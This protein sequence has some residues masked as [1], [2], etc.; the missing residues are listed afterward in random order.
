MGLRNRLVG[1]IEVSG[2]P[3]PV[4]AA[5]LYWATITNGAPPLGGG[6]SQDPAPLPA[7][8]SAIAPLRGVVVGTGPQLCWAANRITVYRA[9]VPLAI[10]SA[11]GH[12][13]VQFARVASGNVRGSDPFFGSPVLPLLEGASLVMVGAGNTTVALYD[14]GLAGATFGR[15]A[16]KSLTYTLRLPVAFPGEVLQLELVGADGQHGNSR[17]ADA[18]VSGETTLVNGGLIAGAGSPY[19]DSDWNGNVAGPLPELW[20]NTSHQ[21]AA[22][23]PAGASS[24]DVE[25]RTQS[26][27]L[28][29][30]MNGVGLR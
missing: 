5:F 18:G 10:T 4:R 2:V 7:A 24:I 26:D 30:V 12:Y 11:A 20:D 15:V 6:N 29:P 9:A 19:R 23:A 16:G 3:T 27:C 25:F 1:G 28:T 21:I 14:R 8:R 13:E 22:A 17:R